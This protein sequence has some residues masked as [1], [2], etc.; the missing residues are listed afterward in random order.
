[1]AI[2]ELVRELLEESKGDI[3]NDINP[4]NDLVVDIVLDEIAQDIV[5]GTPTQTDDF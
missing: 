5:A 1:M 2:E 4:S 3:V